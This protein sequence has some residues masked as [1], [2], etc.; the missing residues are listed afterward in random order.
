MTLATLLSRGATRDV[1]G[2]I[3]RD[4]RAVSRDSRDVG[5]DDVFVAIEGARIDG[6][7]LVPGLQA[8]AVVVSRA[9]DAAAGV[10]VVQVDD[11]KLA[12]AQLAAALHRYPS[13][14]VQLVGVTGTNGKTTVTRL[15]DGALLALGR[16]SGHI[17]TAGNALRGVPE[18]AAFTTPEAPQLQALLRRWADAGA[19]VVAMEVSSIGLA[20]HRVDATRFHVAAFTNLTQD[21]LDFHGTLAAYQQAKARLFEELLR[22]PG[23]LPRA[24]L[25]A[26]DPAWAD[27]GAPA[28]RWTYGFGPSDWQIT[29]VQLDAAGMRMA[30]STPL[31][32]VTLRSPMLGRHNAQNLAC[33]AALLATLGLP[34]DDIARGLAA[35]EGVPGRL[36]R[37]ADPAG[38]LVVVDYAHSPDALQH[39]LATVADLLDDGAALWVVFGCGGDRDR[40]KRPQMGAVAEASGARVVLTSDNPRSEDP[41]A[42]LAAI[43]GGMSAPPERIEPDRAAAIRYAIGAAGPGDAVLIAGKGHE[44]TQEVAGTKH[45]FDDRVQAR[46]ALEA[47]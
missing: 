9:V 15:V 25:C 39:A 38:R 36:E 21:H 47:T 5:P 44:T 33:A 3:H 4:V 43:A 34:L 11:T 31:G 41:D 22:E 12:L 8:A 45:P 19:Q 13:E 23:G 2:E 24:V 29:D 32:P 37:V 1:R 27:M 46:L 16:V 18:P 42:I 30:L 7:D 35:V 28:D 6:H 20:Q 14:A 40:G 10:T 26:D 17:G